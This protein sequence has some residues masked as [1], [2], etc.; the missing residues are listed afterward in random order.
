MS[1]IEPIQKAAITTSNMLRFTGIYKESKNPVWSVDMNIE[2]LTRLL[3]RKDWGS[4]LAGKLPEDTLQEL[5][6]VLFNIVYPT[7]AEPLEE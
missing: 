5:S 1:G 3:V 4:L 7:Y 6:D 2:I